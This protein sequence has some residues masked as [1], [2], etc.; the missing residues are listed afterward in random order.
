MC[1]G[2]GEEPDDPPSF[3]SQPGQRRLQVRFHT[4]Y[5]LVTHYYYARFASVIVNTLS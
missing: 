3:L 1:C 4:I 2:D 5:S